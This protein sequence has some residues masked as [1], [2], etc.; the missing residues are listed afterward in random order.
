MEV[1]EKVLS[2]EYDFEDQIWY[3]TSDGAKDLI[4]KLLCPTN[5]RL[6]AKEALNHPWIL[7]HTKSQMDFEISADVLKR[8]KT[9]SSQ[10]KMQQ[11][12]LNM[13]AHQCN[14]EEVEEIKKIFIRLDLNND[15]FIT[16]SELKEA[17]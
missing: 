9:F 13:I 11:I 4:Q 15:G 8:L 6:S 3:N 1:F 5:Q 14:T 16:L 10:S 2:Y 7:Q 17:L 12:A